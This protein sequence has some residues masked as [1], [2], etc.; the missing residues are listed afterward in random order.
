MKQDDADRGHDDKRADDG[1]NGYAGAREEAQWIEVRSTAATSLTRMAQATAIEVRD[2]QKAFALPRHKVHTLKERALHPLR[3]VGVEE[4]RVLRGISFEVRRGEFFGVVG[5]NGSGKSTLL[6][7][8]AGIYPP[9]SGNIRVSGRLAP[10]IE[11][12]IGFNSDLTARDNVVVNAV[13]M[14]LTRRQARRRFHAIMDFAELGDFVDLKLKNYSSGMLV[15]L[16]FAVMVESDSDILLIDEVLAVGD[17]A[18]QQ[19]CLDVFYDLRERGRTIV[20]VTHDM[21]TVERFCHRAMLLADGSIAIDGEPDEVGR[22]YLAL[23]FKAPEAGPDETAEGAGS[24]PSAPVTVRDVWVEDDSGQRVGGLAP[25]EQMH[26]HVVLEAH[27]AV[28]S[29]HAIVWIDSP[30]RTRVFGTGSGSSLEPRLRPGERVHLHLALSNF[31]SP[32]HYHIG[33]SMTTGSGRTNLVAWA[34][35]AVG[36]IVFGGGDYHGLVALEHTLDI[37]REAASA[38]LPGGH[39]A[40]LGASGPGGP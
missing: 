28:D 4:L 11:L 26:V 32:N 36:L 39:G 21:G 14:G 19:K 33:F 18:F 12:G 7:C 17:A 34:P 20:L 35:D 40:P 23:N 3:R 13:M 25:G 2:L 27:Q 37:E 30:E 5:R 24:K 8:L 22:H 15:R 9:D 6:K 31:L 16:A 10:F 29:P 38:S 1:G